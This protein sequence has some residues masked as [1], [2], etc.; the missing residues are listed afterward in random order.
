MFFM[1]KNDLLVWA[2]N[3]FALGKT[4]IHVV[5]HFLL[6]EKGRGEKKISRESGKVGWILRGGGSSPLLGSRYM[7]RLR[8]GRGQAGVGGEEA[9]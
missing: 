3:I 8:A 4:C 9:G 1:L 2:R 7:R 5:P 6:T